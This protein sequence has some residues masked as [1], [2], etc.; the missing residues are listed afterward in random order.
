M[1]I[2]AY[3]IRGRIIQRAIEI[4][5]TIDIYIVEHFTKDVAK[6]VELRA[7][8]IA[9]RVSFE[10][11]FQIFSYLIQEY[12]P[13]F[14]EAN[15]GYKKDLPYI[16]EERNAYA[17]F[18]IDFSQEALNNYEKDGIITFVKLKNSKEFGISTA[19]NTK[20][21]HVN[22]LLA[23]MNKYAIAIRQLIGDGDTA[24]PPA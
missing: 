21:D 5:S 10:N 23:L 2:D 4:E 13:E 18:P 1:L 3:N 16:I 7:L 22:Q 20:S 19:R 12:N 9:P 11:K 8:V 14:A 24:S 6:Q 15:K 17:H